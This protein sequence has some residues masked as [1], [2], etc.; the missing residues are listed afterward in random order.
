MNSCDTDMKKT[1]K[2]YFK[3][4]CPSEPLLCQRAP[5]EEKLLAETLSD[6]AKAYP[7]HIAIESDAINLSYN[8]LNRLVTDLATVLLQ[9]G[10][11]KNN[12]V[13]IYASRTPLLIIS[14]LATLKIGA[15]FTLLDPNDPV[16]YLDE[17][18]KI[19]NPTVWINLNPNACTINEEKYLNFNALIERRFKI[20]FNL[21][22]IA[23]IEKLV[24]SYNVIR[25]N[26]IFPKISGDDTATITF[27]SGSSGHPKAVMGRYS[28]LSHFQ[29][30]MRTEFNIGH[31]DRF[32]MCSNLSHDPIQRDIFTSICLGGTIVIPSHQ[33]IFTPGEL[34]RWM[35]D[36]QITVCCLTP[37]MCQFLTIYNLMEIKLNCLRK[38]FFVG[39]SLLKKQVEALQNVAPNVDVINLYGSTETQRAVS[40]FNVTQNLPNIPNV[41]PIGQG[42]QDVEILIVN[43]T[44]KQLCDFGEVGEIWVRS[45]YIAKGYLNVPDNNSFAIN[46]FSKLDNDFVYKTGDLGLYSPN[47]GVQ[48]LG[49]IDDQIKID[50]HRVELSHIDNSLMQFNKIKD[51]ITLAVT[52]KRKEHV[53]VAFLVANALDVKIDDE[54]FKKEVRK[55]LEEHLPKYMIPRIF[56]TKKNIPLTKNGKVDYKFLKHNALEY[57]KE[58]RLSNNKQNSLTVEG[59]SDIVAEIL[60]IPISLVDINISLDQLGCT[61]LNYMELLNRIKKI[62]NINLTYNAKMPTISEIISETTGIKQTNDINLT[63]K[64][65]NYTYANKI[66]SD[67][68]VKFISSTQIEID[69]KILDHFCSNSYLGLGRHPAVRKIILDH[70]YED[71]SINSHG[72]MELNGKTIFHVELMDEI[73]QLYNC[74][75]VLLY[76][77]AYMA[78]ISIIPA[79]A[80][81]S[82]HV[83]I[84]SACHKSI[85]DGCTLSNAHFYSFKHNDMEYLEQKLSALQNTPGKKIIISEGLFSMEGTILELPKIRLLA[86]KYQALL[87]VDEACSLGQ[88]GIDGAGIESYFNMPGTIDLRVGTLSKAIPSVGGYVATNNTIFKNLNLRRG[89]IFS[90][91]MPPLQARIAARALKVLKNEPFLVE[92][93]RSNILLW[94]EGLEKIGLNLIKSESAITAIKT[95]D[96]D[97]TKQL[98]KHFYEAGIYVFPALSPWN[99]KG[100]SLIRTS[101]TAMHTSDQIEKALDR[102][103]KIYNKNRHCVPCV[104]WRDETECA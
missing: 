12:A 91:A 63:E 77:S 14:V 71:C 41:V 11:K 55:F 23:D 54:Q 73:K 99:A 9:Q 69:G 37:P 104:S 42:M 43:Q 1:K 84:D 96:D 19:A 59:M 94:R 35:V 5:Y 70:F 31:D 33:T 88:L 64:S 29:K 39:A 28:S 79:L 45:P 32:A 72:A 13:F 68:Y 53:L 56:I 49:R 80:D 98:H 82:D 92:N 76:N 48:C 17:C 27:T 86:D 22:S 36:K 58:T 24:K 50:G 97:E 100:K 74:N 103:S 7:N 60:S 8:E 16:D 6:M 67:K 15:S 20:S 10:I 87:V 25:D 66:L 65:N 26:I 62:Y 75:E 51:A 38:I 3:I 34:P 89:S 102:F 4:P 47:F 46:P 90:G 2:N 57:I 21:A 30:W 81:A 85:I 78:N 44:T 61:S 18:I 93:L 52:N 83:L 101:V 95:H 40:Y